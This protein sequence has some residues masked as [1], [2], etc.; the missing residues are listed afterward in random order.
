MSWVKRN[1]VAVVAIVALLGAVGFGLAMMTTSHSA[2]PTTLSSTDREVQCEYAS[3]EYRQGLAEGMSPAQ[4]L[5]Q[6]VWRC[7]SGQVG[8]SESTPTTNLPTTT[9]SPA[10]AWNWNPPTWTCPFTGEQVQFGYQCPGA[11]EHPT[12]TTTSTTSQYGG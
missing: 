6:A 12:T 11:D 2:P 1:P 10:P 7:A 9:T 8:P 3:P 4:A 5:N